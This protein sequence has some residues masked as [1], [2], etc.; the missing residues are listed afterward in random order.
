MKKPTSNS[1]PSPAGRA[2]F[3]GI[4]LALLAVLC[5]LFARSFQPG[6]IHFSSDAPLGIVAADYSAMPA[7]FRGMWGD[8]N[9]VGAIGGS[10]FPNGS[11]L[12]LWWLG[13][14]GF[15][16]FYAPIC[17]LV[18]GLSVWVFFRQLRFRG[19]VCV[20]GGLAGALNTDFLSY[21][22][23]GLG[24]LALC[25][26]SVFL[27]LAALV[28]PAGNRGWV[29]SILAGAAVGMGVLEGF[30]NG[31]IL[32]LYVAAF[33]VFLAWGT[34]GP[35]WRRLV[36]GAGRVVL[37]A[38]VAGLVATQALSFLVET[39]IQGV[40]GMQQEAR[41]KQERWED[42]T[43]WSLPPVETL[44]IVV[45]GLFGYRMDTPG[46]GNYWGR[47]GERTGLLARHSGSGVYAGVLVVL[48]A[49]WG[50]AQ[51]ARGR[52]GSLTDPE[53]RLVVFWAGA[54]VLSLVLAWGKHAPFYQLLY[55]LPYFSTMRNPIKFTHPLHISLVILFGIGLQALARGYGDRAAREAGAIRAR[56]RA[57][58]TEANRFE[59]RWVAWMGVAVGAGAVSWLLWAASRSELERFLQKAVSPQL[60]PEIA[61]FSTAELAWS[62][63][64]LAAGVAVMILILGGIWSGSRARWGYLALGVVLT[65]DLLRASKPWVSYW[66]FREKYATNPVIEFLRQKSHEHRIGSLPLNLGES[67]GLLRQVYHGEW[68]QH[69]FQYY[70]VQSLDMIQEPRAL[71][72][73]AQFRDTLGTNGL[74][75]M[76]RLWQLTNTRYLIGVAGELADALNREF[77]PVKK[78]FRQCMTFSLTQERPG[79]RIGADTN[80][81]GPFA[82]LEF[83]GALPRAAFY[84]QWHVLNQEPE[85]LQTLVN[86]GFDPDTTVLVSGP[87][88]GLPDRGATNA[89]PAVPIEIKS[90]APNRIGIA[91]QAEAP[92]VLLLNDKNDSHWQV[93]VD[94]RPRPMLRCNFLMR[95]V[96]L[97][98]GAH[99]VEFRFQTPPGPLVASLVSVGACLGILGWV[100]LRKR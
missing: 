99:E 29:K 58:W 17:L 93:F 52:S 71:L 26:A 95:G 78:R 73:N 13:P 49:A 23:W 89:V 67:Y 75:G 80:Q 56:L 50:A 94:G 35:V 83:T 76:V 48:L 85:V 46:G 16:K 61:A 74:T 63:F 33:V 96:A 59:R 53:R 77:D 66:D 40:V 57:W 82:L 2:S 36:G 14:Y 30:D 45:P 41:S 43:Q 62:V 60:A 97:E 10:A 11:Y 8:L 4:G 38:L 81:A 5:F 69:V 20:L 90:Y 12:L 79:G 92:G 37:V 65:G 27:A 7:A 34:T 68:L 44:R 25:V 84:R 19:W 100:S 70:N 6:Q 88:D 1:E 3:L 51:A 47:V 32:S 54:A 9:W 98:A 31:A 55:A 18:V 22:C 24:T 87:V 64:F 42:A 28:S 21:A 39:A 86:P 15:A 91:L 72:E